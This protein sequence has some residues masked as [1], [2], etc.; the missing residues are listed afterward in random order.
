[1][2][3]S[4]GGG[5]W[6]VGLVLSDRLAECRW[7]AEFAILNLPAELDLDC[8]SSFYQI[9]ILVIFKTKTCFHV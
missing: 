8:C 1:M 5:W 3:E 4:T 2:K 9:E 7:K 6:K